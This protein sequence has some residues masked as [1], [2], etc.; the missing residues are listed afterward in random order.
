M[1][2]NL[3]DKQKFIIKLR[4]KYITGSLIF[5]FQCMSRFLVSSFDGSST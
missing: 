4:L 5:D 1:S 3:K 2:L